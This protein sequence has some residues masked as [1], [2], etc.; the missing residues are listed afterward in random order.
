MGPWMLAR[1]HGSPQKR[2]S[3]RVSG[4]YLVGW[5]VRSDDFARLWL[6]EAIRRVLNGLGP[7]LRPPIQLADPVSR[8]EIT[9][10][11]AGLQRSILGRG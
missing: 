1:D 11:L 3:I 4:Q 10:R 9:D 5:R 6:V 2:H 8:I 7:G